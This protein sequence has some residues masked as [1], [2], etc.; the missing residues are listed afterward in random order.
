MIVIINI[1]DC[2]VDWGCNGL[3][4]YLVWGSILCSRWLII[5]YTSDYALRFHCCDYPGMLGC[6][7]LGDRALSL[8]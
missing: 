8:S 2:K 4:S 3:V 5:C 6:W 1:V 7:L